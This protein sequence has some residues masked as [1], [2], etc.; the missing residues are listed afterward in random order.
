M[1]Q[2]KHFKSFFSSLLLL[3]KNKQKD[4]SSCTKNVMYTEHLQSCIIVTQ[5]LT[6]IQQLI[7]FVSIYM[8]C[9]S[10]P[11]ACTVWNVKVVV[12]RLVSLHGM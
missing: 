5:H 6:N 12:L 2:Y 9:H 3:F 1:F 11:S 8:S 10:A 7:S 4:V